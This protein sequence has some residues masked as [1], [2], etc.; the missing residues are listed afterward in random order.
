MAVST[1]GVLAGKSLVQL[2]AGNAHVCA[3]DSA[4]TAYC[5]DPTATGNSAS[6]AT[7]TD[8]IPA[9]TITK[10]ATAA[11]TTGTVSYTSPTLTWTGDLT[12][13]QT[14]TITYTITVDNPDTGSGALT[15]TVTSTAT[16]ST[17]P[18]G[19]SSPGCSV[20]VAVVAGPLS[21]TVPAAASLGSAAP[22]GTRHEAA[23]SSAW[24]PLRLHN[25]IHSY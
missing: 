3:L 13:G 21:I 12:P 15:N 17:C 8:L 7:V 6:T 24:L 19:S 2:A 23:V 1:S 16:G 18:A 20:T 22:G 25:V 14:A 5:W 9:L 4:G 10:T 11:A